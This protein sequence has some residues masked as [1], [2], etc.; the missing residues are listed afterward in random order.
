MNDVVCVGILVADVIARP[1]DAPPA[2]GTLAFVDTVVLRGGGCALNTA[3]ALVHLGLR[4]AVIGKLGADA[5]G[6]AICDLMAKRGVDR[7]AV[8]RDSTV[9]TSVSVVLVDSF[10]ERTFLHARGANATLRADELGEAPFAGRALHLGGTLV[11]DALDGEPAAS[12]LEDARRRGLHTSLDTVF[13]GGAGWDRVVPALPHCDLVTPG[14][15]EALAITGANDPAAAARALRKL[16]AGTAVVTLGAN[17]CY[18]ASDDF[19]G[20]VEA[21]RV[22]AVDG[23]GAGDAFAAGFLYGALAGWPT[24]RSARFASAAGA[25]AT[26]AVGAYEGVGDLEQTLELAGLH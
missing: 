18:V 22:H 24:E 14:L 7:G 12:L 2:P 17:G 16:G 10:G 25:L 3:S 6:D 11:L 21:C 5:F 4:A 1:V 19:A 20:H 8:L 13:A 9:Q 26:R 23:T 15:Q